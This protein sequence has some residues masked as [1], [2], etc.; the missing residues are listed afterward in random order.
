MASASSFLPAARG[1]QPSNLFS[2]LPAASSFPWSV[3]TT[4]TRSPPRSTS[5]QRPQPFP[6]KPLAKAG[7][8][9]DAPGPL[10]GAAPPPP[11]WTRT[12]GR[13]IK[14][15]LCSSV[16]AAASGLA[17]QH[18]GVPPTAPQ[19]PVPVP[20]GAPGALGARCPAGP[21]GEPCR[22]C[23]HAGPAP[24]AATG[25]GGSQVLPAARPGP[26]GQSAALPEPAPGRAPPP[27]GPAADY[28]SR[29]APRR[30]AVTSPGDGESSAG[31]GSAAGGGGRP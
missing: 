23:S 22:A 31:P 4:S 17:P 19:P 11:A 8:G 6:P 29:H 14:Q 18:P 27:G 20:P 21:V 25:H 26:G 16:S 12:L 7:R 1:P 9:I 2:C 3:S 5:P 10:P 30:A 28:N 13:A 24:P 15:F